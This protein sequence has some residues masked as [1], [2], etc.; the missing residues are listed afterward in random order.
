M[1]S[2][3]PT[4]AAAQVAIVGV[5]S[6][7]KYTGLR[8][9]VPPTV[10]LPATQMVEG[11]ATYYVRSATD[12]TAI[13]SAI[14]AA[15]RS[16]D[17]TL[18]VNDLRTQDEQVDRLTAPEALFARL[19]GFFG[20]VTL[21]L[22]GVGLYGLLS[23]LVLRRTAEIG[24][25]LALGARPARVLQMILRESFALVGLGLVLGVVVAFAA[26]RFVESMLFGVSPADPLTYG[27]VGSVIVAVTLLASLL[28][29]FRAA[30]VDPMTAF[31]TD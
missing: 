16:V 7:M 14:R 4:T 5:V 6:D 22:A 2:A 26:S 28:P 15:I 25:R 3:T 20:V 1:F 23:Y 31:R 29:A 10:F 8:Q 12:P 13:G 17:P 19:S 27:S 30:R 9:P 24:L 18:P 11:T 21:I